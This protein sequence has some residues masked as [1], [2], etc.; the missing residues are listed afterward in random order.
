MPPAQPDTSALVTLKAGLN[1]AQVQE[2]TDLITSSPS[3]RGS[4]LA[5]TFQ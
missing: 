4:G 1:R 5:V 2:V 3:E